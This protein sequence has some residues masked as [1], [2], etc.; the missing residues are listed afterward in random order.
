MTKRFVPTPEAY[1]LL[2]EGQIALAE[3]EHQGVRVDKTYL[4]TAIED[5][6]RKIRELEDRMRADPTYRVWRRRYGERTSLSAPA[7]LAGVVFGELG[8]PS[9][10]TTASG[11][12]E[13]ADESAFEHV[14]LP[15][16][17][18]YFQAQK[19][20]KG[21]DTYLTGIRRE[22]VHHEGGIWK[23]HPSYNL[24][25]V[26]TFRSSCDN[27]NWTNVPNR[28]PALAEIV[29]RCYIPSPGNQLVE[30]DYSQIEVRVSACYHCDPTM[31]AYIRD[32]ATD[33][34]RDQACRLFFLRPDQI[35]KPV[36]H[37]SKNLWVFP[38]FYGDFYP[39]CAQNMWE[40]ASNGGLRIGKAA[41]GP[42]LLDHLRANGIT[43]LG[44]CDPKE[45][46]V[47]GTFEAHVQAQER[48]FWDEWLP[49][50]SRWKKDWLQAYYRDGGC[51][52]LTGFPMMGPHKRNDITNYPIQGSSFHCVLWSLPRIN[53]QLRRFRMRSRVIG[54]IH[55]CIVGDVPPGERD[56]YIDLVRDT[57]VEKLM[58]AWPWVIVPLDTEVEVCDVGASWFEKKV[59]TKRDGVWAPPSKN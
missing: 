10:G 17:K 33:M 2:H 28:N 9:R 42:L 45:R 40:A 58:K 37:L 30:I 5:T 23:V 53:A 52:F 56:D 36:R 38:Q 32:P 47:S 25:T 12:R 8:Y 24:H 50:Y 29:R 51:M 27:P 20:R 31:I 49:V 54:E 22:M 7:Q 39:R 13:A 15:F 1:Q 48:Y 46:P 41:D 35:N 21:R 44:A 57:M 59:W 14:D 19:L 43:G 55:D 11:D 16:V 4:E 6:S 34:H 3:V 18:M 26:Q